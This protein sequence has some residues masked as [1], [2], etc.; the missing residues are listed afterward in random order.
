MAVVGGGVVDDVR[1]ER[2]VEGV[3]GGVPDRDADETAGVVAEARD[4]RGRDGLGG[5]DEVDFALAVGG[6][7]DE[8]G[9]AGAERG[10]GALDAG[11]ATALRHGQ[12]PRRRRA[13]RVPRG[14]SS[15]R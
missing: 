15:A 3:G 2:Q 10:D 8:H 9:V 13:G 6:V 5:V 1:E 4:R 14:A 12:S 11:G 7:V